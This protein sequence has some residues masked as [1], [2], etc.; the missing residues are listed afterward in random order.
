MALSNTDLS[1]S[2]TLSSQSPIT[3]TALTNELLAMI[4]K[5]CDL[6]DKISF[7]RTSRLFY[8]I[9]GPSLRR[10]YSEQYLLNM[11]NANFQK[12]KQDLSQLKEDLSAISRLLQC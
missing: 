3:L 4:L 1:Q 10:L 6:D 7:R 12:L 8:S 5:L 9:P 11:I 2:Q